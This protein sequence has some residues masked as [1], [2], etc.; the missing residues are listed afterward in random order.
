MN[1]VRHIVFA[2][3]LILLASGCASS[4]FLDREN[5]AVGAGFKVITPKKPYQLA[6]L[7]K[8]PPDRVTLI[9]YAGKPYYILP[10]LKNHQAYVGGP[11]QYQAYRQFRQA[12]KM[13][14]EH[15]AAAPPSYHVV[16]I[17]ATNWQEF[18]GWD[19]LDGPGWY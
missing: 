17:N 3:S 4:S 15:E 6:L 11:K 1:R 12:Q 7:E 8:L 16:E 5:A 18:E 13:N 19:G 9:Q 14:A 2:F 10:D